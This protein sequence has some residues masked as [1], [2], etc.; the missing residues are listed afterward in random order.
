MGERLNKIGSALVTTATYAFVAAISTGATSY[1][2]TGNVIPG[3]SNL[4]QEAWAAMYM[5]KLDGS[6]LAT[7]D[8]Y[9]KIC[10]R[11]VA[12]DAN[13]HM[14]NQL[15][16]LTE[17]PAPVQKEQVKATVKPAAKEVNKP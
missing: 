4:T 13:T 17:K 9:L 5:K 6:P 14:K 2:Q 11:A 15:E 8:E 7:A 16:D 10:R 12:T 1:Y 3:R